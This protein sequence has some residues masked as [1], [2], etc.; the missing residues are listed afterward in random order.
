MEKYVN[1][2]SMFQE[3]IL[4]YYALLKYSALFPLRRGLDDVKRTS[5]ELDLC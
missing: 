3:K 2:Y 1:L 5:K 4:R